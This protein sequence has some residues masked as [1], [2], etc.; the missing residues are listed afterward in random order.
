MVRMNAHNTRA[1][2]WMLT[3]FAVEQPFQ[4]PE[5]VEY[6]IWQKE[7]CPTSGREHYQVFLRLSMRKYFTQVKEMFPPG[8]HIETARFG[9]KK[10]IDYCSKIESRVE[11]PWSV[12]IMPTSVKKTVFES[13]ASGKTVRDVLEEN[14]CLWR[15]VRPMRDL[16]LV[17]SQPRSWMTEC[18]FLTGTTG[19]GKSKIAQIISSFIGD[20]AWLCPTMEWADGYESQEM[21]IYD[22]V[23]PPLAVSRVLRMVDRY[24]LRLPIKGGFVNYCPRLIVMTSNVELRELFPNLDGKSYL[25]LQRRVTELTVY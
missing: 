9:F 24:P 6:A 20:T 21:V 18:L 8:T 12:G 1:R 19:T 7:K 4:I 23:R 3:S 13:I 16:A 25:A 15:S 11:G 2:D 5:G 22:E 17:M 10:C 14:P